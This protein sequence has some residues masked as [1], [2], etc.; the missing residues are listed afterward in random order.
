MIAVGNG[1]SIVTYSSGIVQHSP[2][3]GVEYSSSKLGMLALTKS[4]AG[5]LGPHGVRVNAIAPGVIERRCR[6]PNRPL[7]QRIH[8]AQ[9]V[10]TPKTI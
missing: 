1:G 2:P 6:G 8:A 5:E 4:A 10:A 3:R 7:G 9:R